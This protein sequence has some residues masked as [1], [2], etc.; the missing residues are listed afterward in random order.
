MVADSGKWA[1]V[2]LKQGSP[3]KQKQTI[4]VVTNICSKGKLY[5]IS[6]CTGCGIL[7]NSNNVLAF[8]GSCAVTFCL[9]PLSVIVGV[10]CHVI[11]C[12]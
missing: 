3:V 1:K 5:G 12:L 8:W 10:V 2:C 4:H 6:N 9:K 7:L 11:F